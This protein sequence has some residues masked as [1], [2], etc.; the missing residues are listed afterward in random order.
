MP[1]LSKFDAKADEDIFLE[2][3]SSSKAYRVFN[4]ST[5]VIEESIHVVFDKSI[6]NKPKVIDDDEDKIIKKSNTKQANH[7]NKINE[8]KNEEK[9]ESIDPSLPRDWRYAYSHPRDQIIGDPS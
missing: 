6:S 7:N 3:S 2:Y 4:K 9:N 8:D 5:L 1:K